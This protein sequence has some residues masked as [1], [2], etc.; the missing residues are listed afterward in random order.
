M[1]IKRRRRTVRRKPPI[2]H[3]PAPGSLEAL[4]AKMKA[5]GAKPVKSW[6]E[7]REEANDEIAEQRQKNA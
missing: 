3:S 1:P 4:M 6:L 2:V 5:N 7:L